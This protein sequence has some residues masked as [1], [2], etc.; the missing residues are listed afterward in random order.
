MTAAVDVSQGSI[1]QADECRE[2]GMVGRSTDLTVLY[3][4][5]FPVGVAASCPFRPDTI[6]SRGIVLVIEFSLD[7]SG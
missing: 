6:K 5:L 7:P 2:I 3:G 4:D 1:G